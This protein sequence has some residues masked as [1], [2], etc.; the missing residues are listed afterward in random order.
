[1]H[2]NS[3]INVTGGSGA[4]KLCVL[5][6]L[7]VRVRVRV[8]NPNGNPNP[9]LLISLCFSLFFVLF[10]TNAGRCRK[11]GGPAPASGQFATVPGERGLRFS[12]FSNS[13]TSIRLRIRLWGGQERPEIFKLGVFVFGRSW[14]TL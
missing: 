6:V 2:V 13:L 1:M 4:K 3:G 7:S 10:W 12:I 5:M 9:K 14:R 11:P 8:S